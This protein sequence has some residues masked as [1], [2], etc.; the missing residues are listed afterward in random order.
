MAFHWQCTSESESYQPD[1]SH[2][3]LQE[4]HFKLCSATMSASD[5]AAYL[6]GSLS[7]GAS[8]PPGPGRLQTCRKPVSCPAS[9]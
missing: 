6:G 3:Q 4:Q 1:L 7:S 8:G 9:T 5:R 2:W